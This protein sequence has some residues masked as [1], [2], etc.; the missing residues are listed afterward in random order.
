MEDSL[1]F[2]Y[3]VYI[4]S[5]I[6]H[7]LALIVHA[8]YVIPLQIREARVQNGLKTLRILMLASGL[9]MV[10]ISLITIF[11]L[12]MRFFV[13]AGDLSRYLAVSLILLHSIGFLVFALIKRKMYQQQ[14]SIKQKELHS[15]M[16]TLERNEKKV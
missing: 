1:L 12:S 8:T 9:T 2:L 15:K 3:I 10:L 14:Y 13:P 16:A 7:I 5:I 6:I 11:V 4:G